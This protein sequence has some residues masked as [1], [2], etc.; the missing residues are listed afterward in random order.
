MLLL[1][2]I[3]LIFFNFI[4]ASLL[5]NDAKFIVLNTETSTFECVGHK[6]LTTLNFQ[7]C[8]SDK[9]ALWTCWDTMLH[10]TLLQWRS[11]K[12][13][14]QSGVKFT[15]K[16]APVLP[17]FDTSSTDP[18]RSTGVHC[19]L[20]RSPAVRSDP[21]PCIAINYNQKKIRQRNII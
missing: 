18:S 16:G 3:V 8:E 10:C 19:G 15:N 4:R 21:L 14:N 9:A 17:I 13:K 11:T 5:S 20:P 1:H 7:A 12:L 2:L 6:F